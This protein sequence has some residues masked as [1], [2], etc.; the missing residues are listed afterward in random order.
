M[1]LISEVPFFFLNVGRSDLPSKRLN[2][3][4]TYISDI[5]M[6]IYRY[7]WSD[8]EL[9]RVYSNS[10]RVLKKKLKSLSLKGTQKSSKKWLERVKKVYFN[11]F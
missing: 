3:N 2:P 1:V 9:I 4:D 6:Y 10:V 11:I 8:I 7:K 5:N